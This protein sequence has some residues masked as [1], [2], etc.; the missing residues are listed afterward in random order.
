MARTDPSLG[1]VVKQSIN[2]LS[3]LVGGPQASLESIGERQLRLANKELNKT[4][5]QKEA[6]ARKFLGI[7]NDMVKADQ[8]QRMIAN[9]KAR[10]QAF[11]S[12]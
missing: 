5:L 11:S 6:Y 10:N 3:G 7:T 4:P 1:N 2:R 12:R 9:A 8:R